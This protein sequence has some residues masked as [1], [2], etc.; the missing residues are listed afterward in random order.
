M[1]SVGASRCKIVSQFAGEA[2]LLA[3]LAFIVSMPF[4]MHYLHVEGFAD[5]INKL[6]LF[7]KESSNPAYLHNQP[8]T[9]FATVTIVGYLFMAIVAVVGAVIPAWRATRI[10]PA[11]AMRE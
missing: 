6:S 9:H 8:L 11:D 3:T 4:V 7:N 2:L 1:R 10:E 5:P